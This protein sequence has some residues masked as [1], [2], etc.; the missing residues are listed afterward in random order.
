MGMITILIHDWA[1]GRS[2]IRM[3]LPPEAKPGQP[4]AMAEQSRFRARVIADLDDALRETRR[5]LSGSADEPLDAGLC[6]RPESR[7]SPWRE[8]DTRLWPHSWD[9]PA[10]VVECRAPVLG[11]VRKKRDGA[12]TNMH[13]RR[14]VRQ[15]VNLVPEINHVVIHAGDF[16]LRAVVHR[17]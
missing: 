11:I 5:P 10:R 1:P 2:E 15:H 8:R 3:K 17:V 6:P 4:N 16:P 13:N 12:V 14:G 9:C 7:V